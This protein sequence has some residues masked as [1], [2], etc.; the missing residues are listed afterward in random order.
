MRPGRARHFC[1]TN[2]TRRM[3]IFKH[4]ATSHERRK[5]DVIVTMT[6]KT[7]IADALFVNLFLS[8]SCNTAEVKYQSISPSRKRVRI[9]TNRISQ[10]IRYSRASSCDSYQDFIEFVFFNKAK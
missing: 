7:Y 4:S 6:K 1:F 10:L 5:E 2:D 3:T 8:C 9:I